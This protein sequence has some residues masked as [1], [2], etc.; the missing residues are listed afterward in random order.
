MN[1]QTL[2]TV[3]DLQKAMPFNIITANRIKVDLSGNKMRSKY[4]DFNGRIKIQ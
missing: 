4:S 3:V 1:T 2:L